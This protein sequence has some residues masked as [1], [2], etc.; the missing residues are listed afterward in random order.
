VLARLLTCWLY[1][2]FILVDHIELTQ[3]TVGTRQIFLLLRKIWI[4]FAQLYQVQGESSAV[5]SF[6]Y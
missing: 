5:A 1:N 2:L 3:Y 4:Q 6:M